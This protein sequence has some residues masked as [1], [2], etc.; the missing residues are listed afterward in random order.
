[1]LTNTFYN[2]PDTTMLNEEQQQP[3]LIAPGKENRELTL[4]D[5]RASLC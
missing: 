4:P 2:N 3:K 5:P 1:M